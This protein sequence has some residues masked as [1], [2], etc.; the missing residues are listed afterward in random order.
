M[1]VIKTEC[2]IKC[3]EH[4]TFFSSEADNRLITTSCA[5]RFLKRERGGAGREERKGEKEELLSNVLTLPVIW[6]IS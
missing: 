1:A 5:L 6:L 3:K 2:D 4:Y